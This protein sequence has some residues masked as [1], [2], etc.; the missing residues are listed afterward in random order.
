MKNQKIKPPRGGQTHAGTRVSAVISSLSL[1][2]MA[3]TCACVGGLE[4]VWV[5]VVTLMS[6]ALSAS[7]A[8]VTS[9]LVGSASIK[10][11]RLVNC[12]RNSAD[13]ICE[14]AAGNVGSNGIIWFF[15]SAMFYSQ[16]QP[17]ATT[18]TVLADA[19]LPPRN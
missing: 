9:V 3:C 6:A 4:M 2:W 13:E 7:M 19:S 8:R 17:S 16:C 1:F 10:L 11:L 12:P 15:L 5:S 14:L 18:D